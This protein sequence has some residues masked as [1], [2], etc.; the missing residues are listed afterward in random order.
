MF[1][2]KSDAEIK[3]EM[4]KNIVKR[5]ESFEFA[6][7]VR[8]SSDRAPLT[9]SEAFEVGKKVSCATEAE[10]DFFATILLTAHVCATEKRENLFEILAIRYGR[11]LTGNEIE[12][13]YGGHKEKSCR[14]KPEKFVNMV[15]GWIEKYRWEKLPRIKGIEDFIASHFDA[16]KAE[17]KIIAA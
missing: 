9:V 3:K 2:L 12:A 16:S 6:F 1:N 11:F 5:L 15:R 8:T 4:T 7:D 14:V 17:A 13:F 10:A